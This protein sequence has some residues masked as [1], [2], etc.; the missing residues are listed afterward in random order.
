[1]L[2]V[3]NEE[4]VPLRDMGVLDA[5]QDPS[6]SHTMAYPFIRLSVAVA[7]VI[8]PPPMD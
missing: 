2:G 1:M 6:S 5:P 8:A 3:L 7:V 4:G